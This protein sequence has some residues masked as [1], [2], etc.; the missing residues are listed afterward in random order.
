MSDR[1]SHREAEL[2]HA[3]A[4][5]YRSLAHDG[6]ILHAAGNVSVRFRE[7]FLITPTG[8][9]ADALGDHAIVHVGMD[10]DVLGEGRPSSEWRFHRDIYR[11]R[12][13]VNAIV[14]THS[15]AATALACQRRSL[16]PF[17]YMIAV[18]GGADIRC[19]DY[20]LFGTQDL[21]DCVV[22]ALSERKAC[23]MANHG[24][25]ATGETLDAAL[26]LAA[27]VEHLCDLYQRTSVY[28]PPVLLSGAE[29]NEALVAFRS[30]AARGVTER[31]R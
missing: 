23:L 19:A 2:R 15:P 27:E 24:M 13:D 31:V 30:Y 8:V 6:L 28:G 1:G 10:G 29:M 18:A 12:P 5:A 11:A 17:H 14:H 20:A 7:T 9:R 22:A 16:P 25:I 21:S 26:A 3:I 4:G